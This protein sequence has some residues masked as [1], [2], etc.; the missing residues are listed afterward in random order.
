MLCQEVRERTRPADR[1]LI[2]GFELVSHPLQEVVPRE[3]W[4]LPLVP[5]T[6]VVVGLLA[7]VLTQELGPRLAGHVQPAH[8]LHGQEQRPMLSEPVRGREVSHRAPPRLPT[9]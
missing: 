5:A 9:A 1:V 3:R 7:A 8:G 4:I 6:V 2:Y